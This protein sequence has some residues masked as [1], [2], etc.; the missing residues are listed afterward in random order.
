MASASRASAVPPAGSA[1]V[2]QCCPLPLPRFPYL[3]SGQLPGTARH[4]LEWLLVM[5][6]YHSDR[7]VA[8]TSRK[9]V[10][11]CLQHYCD[12]SVVMPPV[13]R[14]RERLRRD[15][16]ELGASLGHMEIPCLKNPKQRKTE[17]WKLQNSKRIMT[18]NGINRQ[19]MGPGEG[20][21]QGASHTA[22]SSTMQSTAALLPHADFRRPAI[23]LGAWVLT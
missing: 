22:W 16:F 9:P 21:Q 4:F 2:P 19:A 10:F 6:F 23:R 18:R 11:L 5:A 13:T 14:A 1:A 7:E 12:P 15:C 17:E 3:C 20:G 8:G